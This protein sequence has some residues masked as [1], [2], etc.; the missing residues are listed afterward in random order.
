[1]SMWNR[2]L[3]KL[4]YYSYESLLNHL[5]IW[6]SREHDSP[7]LKPSAAATS[8]AILLTVWPNW[9]SI[10]S[11]LAKNKNW[12]QFAP[13]IFL[14]LTKDKSKDSNKKDLVHSNKRS[15]SITGL[16][17]QSREWNSNHLPNLLYFSLLRFYMTKIINYYS[18]LS[19][20]SFTYKEDLVILPYLGY[21]LLLFYYFGKIKH[22]IDK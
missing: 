16:P 13:L 15:E 2:S 6:Q 8:L 14:I 20:L 9:R 11:T 3:V 21:T 7:I 22:L 10:H 5:A 1:M 4:S 19:L 18:C 12:N 17:N